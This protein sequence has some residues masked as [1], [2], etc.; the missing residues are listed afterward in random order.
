MQ[1]NVKTDA[2]L[3]K[4]S[5]NWRTAIHRS[6]QTLRLRR[7]NNETLTKWH[8]S[9]IFTYFSYLT[10]Y[11]AAQSTLESRIIVPPPPDC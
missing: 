8:F 9:K 10:I 7:F 3:P 6:I 2:L 4:K 5:V 1:K 11:L